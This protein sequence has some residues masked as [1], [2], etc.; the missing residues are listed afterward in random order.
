MILFKAKRGLEAQL[1]TEIIDGVIYFCT[2]T[3]NVFFDFHDTRIQISADKAKF[4]SDGNLI[5]GTYAKISDIPEQ[6]QVDW[7]QIDETA[8]DFIKNKPIFTA[9][10]GLAI[11]KNENNI[12]VKFNN[13]AILIFN[14]GGTDFSKYP[15][16]NI[17]DNEAGGQTAD[18]SNF[19]DWQ[20]YNNANGQTIVL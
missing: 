10:N 18:I 3:G 7:S 12:K 2:D 9:G 6:I 15:A 14:G 8:K 17:F 16:L 19:T 20:I 4:D 5:T 11:E 1:P 13:D